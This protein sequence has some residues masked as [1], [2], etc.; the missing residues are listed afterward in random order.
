MAK[1]AAVIFDYYETLARLPDSIREPLFDDIA[2]R[3]GTELAPGE[4]YRH[5]RQRIANDLAVRLGGKR[6]PLDGPT[7]AFL[8]FRETWLERFRQ[9]FDLWGVD[10]PGEVG[11]DAYRDGHAA[12][13]LY[14][15]ATA[16]IERLHGRMR[17]A[18]LSDA[19]RDF[20][21][22]SIQ[23]NGLAV[24]AVV[25]S[26]DV[27]AYKPHVSLFREVCARLGIEPSAAVYVGDSPWADIE[28][29]RRAGMQAVWINRHDRTWPDE[30]EPPSA[31]V[32]SLEELPP[33]LA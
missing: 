31:K 2:Q 22:G 16:V 8:T 27:R 5:W 25:A 15:D 19:D 10:A 24:D 18:V 26:E 11:A 14:P 32:R 9:L 12:A 30:I 6:P 3:V 13:D 28:G 17:V 29:A 21:D 4:A 33:L 23:R 7:P 1:I 20:L